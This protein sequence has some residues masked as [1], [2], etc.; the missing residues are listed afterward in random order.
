MKETG[1]GAGALRFVSFGH[2]LFAASMITIGVMGLMK[3]EFVL[4]WSGVPEGI[5]V[6]H[7]LAYLCALVSVGSGL[8]TLWKRTAA[9]TAG[10]LLAYLVLW[11][12]LFRAPLVARTPTAPGNW[13]VFGETSAMIAGAWV[14]LIGFTGDRSGARL[15]FVTS[16]VGLRIARFFYALGV[17]Q[18]GIGHFTFLERTVG[19]VPGWLPWH[20]GWAYFTGGA[21]IAAGVAILAGVLARQAALLSAWELTLFTLL[22]WVPSVIRGPNAE[23]WNEFVESC[24]LTGTAWLVTE[25]YR[26]IRRGTQTH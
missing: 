1:T 14:L 8:G 7:T 17:I 19:M 24:V 16:D 20:I 22:V 4:I 23:Q 26:S 10:A 11:L 6:R 13:W 21:L 12:A 25:S 15:G 18:F 2:V 9:F 3:G 5:P